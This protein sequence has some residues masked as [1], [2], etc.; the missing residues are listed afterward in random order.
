[1]GGLEAEFPFGSFGEPFLSQAPISPPYKKMAKEQNNKFDVKKFIIQLEKSYRDKDGNW[2]KKL[3][4]YL[5]VAGRIAWMR[6]EQGEKWGIRTKIVEVSENHAIFRALIFDACRK[7]ISSATKKETKQG[8]P[9]FIE[10]AETGAIGR[11][12]ALA[13]Y[14]TQF[15]PE[16]E[17][18]ERIVDSPIDTKSPR[19]LKKNET[20]APNG[21]IERQTTKS[22]IKEVGIDPQDWKPMYKVVSGRPTNPKLPASKEQ[23]DW[24]SNALLEAEIDLASDEP[25][26]FV[27]GRRPVLREVD[28]LKINKG[29]ACDIICAIK[30]GEL[31]KIIKK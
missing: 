28:L 6:E 3:V 10:K 12:L 29:D 4:P 5:P 26:I 15:A 31:D 14:G 18:G 11:A 17:E 13:G 24:V 19:N 7:L 22:G 27:L 1:M 23:T 8:F 20:L 16:F 21:T 2:Q 30:K 25:I 9:D